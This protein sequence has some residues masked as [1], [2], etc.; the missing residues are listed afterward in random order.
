MLT[1]RAAPPTGLRVT[2]E[3]VAEGF[4]DRFQNADGFVGNFRSDT[5]AGQGSK[6]EEHGAIVW[7]I[8]VR[9]NS[10]GGAYIR[11]KA[12]RSR[13]RFVTLSVVNDRIPGK[14]YP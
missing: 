14:L 5:V 11:V 10:R 13:P 4:S 1:R 6:V 3:L 12:L 2:D 8:R 9:E 7:R